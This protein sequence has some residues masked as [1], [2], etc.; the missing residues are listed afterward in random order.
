MRD[1]FS[2]I[3]RMKEAT[4]S[5]TDLELAEK[6]GISSNTI[7]TWKKRGSIPYE[8][9]DEISQNA[10]IPFDWILRGGMLP[11]GQGE[12]AIPV[13][14]KIGPGFPDLRSEDD[15]FSRLLLPGAPENSYALVATDESMIPVVRPDDYLIFVPAQEIRSGDIVIVCNEWGDVLLRR[16]RKKNQSGILTADNP[17]YPPVSIAKETR[18]IGKV[19]DVWRRV[20]V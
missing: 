12:G 3:E 15:V 13:L 2:I 5:R 17:E 19:I 11:Q 10:S 4:G 14:K 20:R 7:S 18:V 9:I 8:K 16:Y 1:I 6:I